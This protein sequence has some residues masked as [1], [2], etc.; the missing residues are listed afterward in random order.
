MMLQIDNHYKEPRGIAATARTP[1]LTVPLEAV[2]AARDARENDARHTAALAFDGRFGPYSAVTL[3]GKPVDRYA[4]VYPRSHPGTT[5]P[6]GWALSDQSMQD[7]TVQ[8]G[9]LNKA[10]LRKVSSWFDPRLQCKPVTAK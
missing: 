2:K 7:L 10:E 1:E 8:L 4:H 5:A 6:L 9:G 3:D